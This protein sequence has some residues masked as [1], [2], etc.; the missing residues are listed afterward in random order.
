V[1][2]WGTY[3]AP[4]RTPLLPKANRQLAKRMTGFPIAA[5]L[6]VGGLCLGCQGSV[7]TSARIET[8]DPRHVSFDGGSFLFR[9]DLAASRDTVRF[10]TED[11]VLGEPDG[12]AVVIGR[13]PF[14]STPYRVFVYEPDSVSVRIVS[15]KGDTVGDYGAIYLKKGLYWLHLE[16]PG[17]ESGTYLIQMAYRGDTKRRLWRCLK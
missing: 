15:L 2:G 13:N 5:A 7:R 11:V 6:F 4:R 8:D 12:P 16:C 1:R 14:S 9:S 3:E 10:Y 17:E